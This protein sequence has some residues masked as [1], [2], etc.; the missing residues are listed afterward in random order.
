MVRKTKE[1]ALA[2]RHLL[3]D[4]ASRVF[5][6]GGVGHTTLNDIAAAAGLTRGAVYWHFQNKSDL[7]NALWERVALPMQQALDQIRSEFA[8]DVLAMTRAKSRWVLRQVVHDESTRQ[9]MSILLLRCEFV[10]ELAS[11]RDYMLAQ[12]D[13]CIGQLADEF[14]LAI[15]SGQLPV[16]VRAQGAAISLLALM[17][18]LCMHWLLNPEAFDLEQVGGAALDAFLAGLAIPR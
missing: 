11:A 18:G 5:S 17:D 2:T 13:Q 4:A 12:R 7:I 8:H 1:D 16:T 9:F 15:A 14:A 10:A 6:E 3:L